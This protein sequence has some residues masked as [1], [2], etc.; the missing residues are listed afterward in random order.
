MIYL[1]NNATTPLSPT[2]KKYFIE[3]L[4]AFGNASTVYFLGQQ[5]DQLL[6]LARSRVAQALTAT[7]EEI[8]F[9]SGGTESNNLAIKG[10]AYANRG[11]GNHLITTQIEHPSVLNVFNYLQRK[12]FLVTYLPVTS[13]GFVEP[14]SLA[15]AMR[16]ETIMV[17][18]MA[19]NN[20]TGVVQ[21]IK[22]LVLVAKKKNPELIFHTDAV[23]S[24][25]KMPVSVKDWNVDLLSLSGHKFYA[26]KGIGALYVRRGVRV[27]S[28]CEGGP[29]ERGLRPGTEPIPLLAALGLAI[30]E[31]VAGLSEYAKLIELKKQL[32]T[33]I[34]NIRPDVVLNG[35][36]ENCLV[37]TLNFSIPG[38]NAEAAVLELSEKGLYIGNGAACSSGKN[39]ASYVLKAMGVPPSLCLS[40]LRLSLA[41][42]LNSEAVKN[43]SKEMARVLVK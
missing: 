36:W 5:A 12:G 38:L 13:T 30:S 43:T 8:V 2:V 31:A 10:V 19:A 4:E 22:D 17:S 24:V 18:I 39:E 23:Q 14:Q 33:A 32:W 41:V 20:E 16:P 34:K 26:P 40:A 21:P 35:S 3:C 25:G 42:P 28:L 9:T 11:K 29:Q 37:N 7:P 27:E 15:A 6:E 1:D